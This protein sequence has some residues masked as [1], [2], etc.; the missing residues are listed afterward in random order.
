LLLAVAVSAAP[1]VAITAF[2]GDLGDQ[3]FVTLQGELVE[4]ARS[5]AVAEWDGRLTADAAT[6]DIAFHARRALAAWMDQ[7]SYR[8]DVGLSATGCDAARWFEGGAGVLVVTR[9]TGPGAEVK[10][11]TQAD[12]NLAGASSLDWRTGVTAAAHVGR[13][14]DS[15]LLT[16]LRPGLNLVMIPAR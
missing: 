1:G 11:Q 9:V 6:P 3:Q 16:G 4:T 15:L 10:L 12:L 5:G 8:D 13:D 2:R 7:G 14:G